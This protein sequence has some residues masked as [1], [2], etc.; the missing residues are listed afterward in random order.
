M[1][2]LFSDRFHLRSEQR[3]PGLGNRDGIEDDCSRGRQ[4][5]LV[6]TTSLRVFQIVHNAPA[7][8]YNVTTLFLPL[9]FPFNY[10]E[11]A[12]TAG[13]GDTPTKAVPHKRP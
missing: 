8:I 5:L 11:H 12:R 2:H 9:L 6:N 13:W 10:S 3:L 7:Q 1:D 4:S